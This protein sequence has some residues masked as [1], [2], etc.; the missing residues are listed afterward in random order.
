MKTFIAI[1]FKN[2]FKTISF[3]TALNTQQMS[4]SFSTV[5]WFPVKIVDRLWQSIT[6]NQVYVYW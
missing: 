2:T 6:K 5:V 3:I 4:S 1:A